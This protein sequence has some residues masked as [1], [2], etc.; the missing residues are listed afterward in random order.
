MDPA[1][2]DPNVGVPPKVGELP[3]LGGDPNDGVPPKAGV[4]VIFRDPPNVGPLPKAAGLWGDV[5]RKPAWATCPSLAPKLPVAPPPE[6]LPKILLRKGL[7]D[8]LK[9]PN[10]PAPKPA[11]DPNGVESGSVVL[12]VENGEAPVAEAC[13]N[14]DPPLPLLNPELVVG[15][16]NNDDPEDCVDE[17]PNIP[18]PCDA[19]LPNKELDCPVLPNTDPVV[20]EVPKR[21]T[22]G[23]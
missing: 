23:L 2:E 15:G 16:T 1:N 5:T 9:P 6:E 7:L 14:T 20:D 19:G 12:G 3:N 18:E 17:P 11:E 13:P 21:D 10:K 22:D 4:P 8:V